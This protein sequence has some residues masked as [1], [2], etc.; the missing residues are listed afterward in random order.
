MDKNPD[1]A[2]QL[3][4]T[5]EFNRFADLAGKLFRVPKAEVNALDAERKAKRPKA[6]KLSSRPH[7][8]A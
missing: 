7:K 2:K 4:N 3:P 1:P 6:A 5:P 8:S